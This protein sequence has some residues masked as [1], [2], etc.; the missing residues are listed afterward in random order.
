MKLNPQ[1]RIED[2]MDYVDLKSLS[3]KIINDHRK[4]R[5]KKAYM[6]DHPELEYMYFNK[7]FII[8][9]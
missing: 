6:D 8:N 2:I 1:T 5:A 3:S 4:K 7:P 9:P